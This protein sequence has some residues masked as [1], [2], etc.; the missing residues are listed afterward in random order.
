MDVQIDKSW[1]NFLKEE[2]EKEYF[3]KLLSFVK[4]EYL[5]KTIFPPASKIF[6]AF[7]YC[8]LDDLNVVILGQD[9]YHG[10][11]QANGLCFSVEDGVKNP[12]S[13]K[14]I[15]KEIDA[16]YG[17]GIPESGDLSRWAKQGV[18]MLNATLTVEEKKP[19]S[20]HKQG[21]ET[22]TDSVI[23]LISDKK[24]NV[25]FVLWGAYAQQK[26]EFIDSEKHLI[27]SS[28]HPSPF[29][30]YRGFFGNNHFKLINEHLNKLGK[31]EIV[32]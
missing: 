15:F 22:F 5:S 6:A 28:A 14:N 18:L 32:W 17:C 8:K 29:S 31:E 24:E 16:E 19:G 2:F 9:P 12:P 26:A 20:H 4:E 3:Q 7:D 11:G 10:A 27:L 30:A 1:N 13:L 23:K 25:V 21:W